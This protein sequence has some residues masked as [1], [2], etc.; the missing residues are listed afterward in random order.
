MGRPDL[1]LLP[2]SVAVTL[3]SRCIQPHIPPKLIHSHEKISDAD[4]LA[5]ALLQKLHKVSYFSCWWRFLKLNHFPHSPS[6]P[7]AHIRLVRLTPVIEQLAT[8]VQHW[9]SSSWI[10]S[11][12]P[13]RHLSALHGANFLAP[14]MGSAPLDRFTVSSCLPGAP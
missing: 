6:D 14:D 9:T 13:S 11:P 7:Q 4:L 5:V 3:L 8:E 1:A 10:R 12:C 2:L